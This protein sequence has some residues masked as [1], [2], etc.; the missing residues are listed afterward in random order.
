MSDEEL[1]QHTPEDVEFWFKCV[2]GLP[3]LEGFSGTGYDANGVRIPWGSGPHNVKAYREIAKIVSPKTIFEIGFNLGYSASM[4]LE[5]LPNASIFT[6]DIS[7]KE[8][9]LRAADI[10]Q[11]R[12]GDRFYFKVADSKIIFNSKGYTDMA[13]ID[14]GHLEED[15]TH[16]I[17]L[18][19]NSGIN[20]LVLDDWI[21]RFGPGVQVSAAKFPI[22]V[23]NVWGNTALL[24]RK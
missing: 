15:V 23:V 7:N 16:D 20:W 5:L 24:K 4:W 13:F 19:L 2:N 3:G 21:P 18:C 6:I 1:M 9:T 8:E 11:D 22:E 10:L 12:Y 17:Q 14:G